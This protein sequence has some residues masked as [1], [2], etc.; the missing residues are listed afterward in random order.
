MKT[1]IV[2]LTPALAMEWQRK[3]SVS[4]RP[5]NTKHVAFLTGEMTAGRWKND[6]SPIRFNRDGSVID[7]QHRIAAVINSGVPTDV[8]VVEDL[9]ADVFATIDSGRTRKLSDVLACAGANQSDMVSSAAITRLLAAWDDKTGLSL[10]A[11]SVKSSPAAMLDV[12]REHQEDIENA[13]HF[14]Y[15]KKIRRRLC[16]P[17]V[18]GFAYLLFARISPSDAVVFIDMVAEGANLERGSGPWLLSRY[19]V[20]DRG[21]ALSHPHVLLAIIIKAWNI[22]RAGRCG[23]LLVYRV[24]ES[25]P[26]PQ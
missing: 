2:R 22:W 12:F 26:I 5:L 4:Q 1:R 23:D 21:H 13:A 15:S 6:G 16:R 18:L 24:T 10:S 7:G 11:H 8:L 9:D 17:S 25:F 3:T 20:N 14:V 19:F